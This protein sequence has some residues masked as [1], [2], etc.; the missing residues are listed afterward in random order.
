LGKIAKKEWRNLYKY[1]KMK[2]LFAP[3]KLKKGLQMCAKK[4]LMLL[5]LLN[6]GTLFSQQQYVWKE[7]TA[8][9][10][11]PGRHDDAWFVNERIGWVVN[12]YGHIYK[13][14]DGGFSWETQL[15]QPE[16]DFR[17]VVFLDSLTGFVGNLGTEEYGGGTDTTILY[18]TTDGGQSFQ[19]I[20]NLIIGQKPRGICGMWAVNDTAIFAVGRV[21]GPAFFVKST[22]GGNSWHS[23]SL[24]SLAAGLI[25]CYFISPDTGFAVGLTNS[26]HPNSSGIILSTVDGGE[27]WQV[28]HIT[29]RTG[30]WCWKISFPSR[31]VGYVSLQRN[32]ETPIYFLKTTDGGITWQEKLFSQSHYYVQGIGF[33]NDSVG[34]IGGTNAH[35]TYTSSD[36]GNTWLNAGFGNR[37]N[38]FRFVNDSV[39]YAVGVTVYKMTRTAVSSVLET[40]INS[41]TAFALHQNYPNPFNPSTLLSFDLPQ[42]GEVRLD[43]YD[44]QGRQV[45]T[46][47]A[48]AYAAGHHSVK[49]YGTNNT[50]VAVS[51]GVY[52][53]RLTLQS[54]ATPFV[55]TRKMVLVR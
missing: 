49:W 8:A 25:D 11:S 32:S 36:G 10:I 24:D 29:S 17:S 45:K 50:G 16:T 5:L 30:E 44:M 15:V 38:R 18:R 3:Q 7:L 1:S 55:Q 9:P 14:S 6:I 19:P 51:S 41:P 26:F 20:D 27:T 2:L 21:R 48:G 4:M 46:V 23:K 37:I 42:P 52:F 35:P 47:A 54:A 34:W 53:Y 40:P 28:A 39:G 22:D 12:I 33:V 43:V 31:K 13:T